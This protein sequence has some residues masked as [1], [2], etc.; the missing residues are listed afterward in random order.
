M[1]NWKEETVGVK[2]SLTKTVG[3]SGPVRGGLSTLLRAGGFCDDAKMGAVEDW[4]GL[5]S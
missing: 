5:R 4:K 2:T 3:Q 1:P